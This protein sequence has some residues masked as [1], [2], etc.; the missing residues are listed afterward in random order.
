MN[1]SRVIQGVICTQNSKFRLPVSNGWGGE[2]IK[3]L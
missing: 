1:L 3:F 2:G